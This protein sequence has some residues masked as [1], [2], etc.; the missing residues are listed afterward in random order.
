V[1]VYGV[2]GQKIGTY[3]FTLGQYGETNTPEMV[4]WSNPV[5][6]VFFGSKRI[7]T[8]DRLGTAKYNQNNAAQSFYPYGEDRGTMEPND[9]LK[10]ATYTRDAATGL[11]YAD[12]RY[13]AS[14]FGRMM[15]PDPYK[16]SAGP[17]NPASWNRYS[18]TR[19]DPVNRFDPG[20][21]RDQAAG[22]NPVQDGCVIP[23]GPPPYW[24]EDTCTPAPEQGG[25]GGGGGASDANSV[26]L[27]DAQYR[28][29]KISTSFNPTG[30]C[31]DFLNNLLS[32][33]GSTDI[34]TFINEIKS[35]AGQAA[36]NVYDGPSATTVQ[37]T[38]AAFGDSNSNGAT[39]VAQWFA[40]QG[41]LGIALSQQNGAAIFL[42]LSKGFDDQ[43]GLG[44]LLH[45]LLHKQ[46]V[47]GGFS[48]NYLNWALNDAGAPSAV[49]GQEDISSRIGEICFH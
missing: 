18:Y 1:Y 29:N 30:K 17:K 6:A 19:G 39:T 38:E 15:S 34:N 5:L 46:A 42:D 35:T 24:G 48:H 33:G 23:G 14:N 13:Y 8:F 11:D 16:A 26:H 49:V 32:T 31:L 12:Q 41:S 25:G 40:Q 10:F 3:T 47:D 22:T 37:L 4:D 2:D 28:L 45:E 20:G 7:G 9:S 21:L 27:A 36:N 44:I 43:Y